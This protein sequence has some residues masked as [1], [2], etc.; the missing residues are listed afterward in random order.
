MSIVRAAVYD[1]GQPRVIGNGDLLA[2]N[3]IIQALASSNAALQLTGAQVTSGILRRTLP[4]GNYADIFPAASDLIAALQSQAYIGTGSYTPVGV[5]DGTSFRLRYINTVAF[6]NTPTI[7]TGGTLGNSTAI[8]ASSVKDYLITVTSGTPGSVVTGNTTNGSAVITNMNAGL[9]QYITAGQ[10]ITGTGI[11]AAATVLSVQPG[12]G[13]TISANAT[14]TNASVAL[15]F[16][17]S[18]RVDG[19]GQMLL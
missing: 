3:E 8:A 15:T 19:I 10:L 11:P 9:L 7:G 16:G 2:N 4:A 6:T 18:Y 1:N 14:A 5:P 12:V 17:P 13:V